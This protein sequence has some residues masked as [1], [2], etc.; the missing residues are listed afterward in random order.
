MEDQGIMALPMGG[1]QAPTTAPTAQAVPPELAAAIEASRSM[2]T[3]NEVSKNTLEALGE[4]DPELVTRFY[5][6]LAEMDL[7]PEVI[8][9]LGQMV[10][11]VLAEPQNY[12]QIRA[13]FIAE[14]V[15]ED[16]LPLEFDP[17]YFAA[18]N[19]ALDE[20][21][22]A[23]LPE[24]PVGFADGGVVMSPIA[25]QLASMGR[26]G[27]TMLAHI[28][29]SE[30]RMLRRRGGSGT[31]NPRTGLPEFF[32]KS[33]AKS[34]GNVFKGV[35]NAVKGVVKGLG[36]VIKDIAS[37]PLGRIAL[38]VAAVYFMG[39]AGLNFAGTAGSITG[40]TGATALG[41]NTAIASTVI[42]VASGQKFKDALKSGAIQ[43]LM[44]YG[45][46]T[47]MK[48]DPYAAAQAAEASKAS[49]TVAQAPTDA[50]PN[51]TETVS[52]GVRPEVL[53]PSDVSALPGPSIG[54]D[55]VI[56]YGPQN[57]NF[58]QPMQQFA[59]A[60]TGTATD[61]TTQATTQAAGQA[62]T[63]AAGQQSNL[64]DLVSEGGTKV[65]D[66]FFPKTDV[67]EVAKLFEQYKADL[68]LKFPGTD[69]KI[70]ATKAMEMAEKAA[71]PTFGTG[72]R[73]A[74]AGLTTLALTGGFTPKQPER[75]GIVPT[76]TGFDLLRRSPDIYGVRVGGGRTVYPSEGIMTLA[77]GGNVSTKIQKKATKTE[78]KAERL[79]AK[80]KTE[81]ANKL[82][83]KAD[84]LTAK[85][86]V[87]SGSF[88]SPEDLAVGA[89]AGQMVNPEYAQFYEMINTPSGLRL[90]GP[91]REEGIG[92]YIEDRR[93][94]ESGLAYRTRFFQEAA[95][96]L[97]TPDL[98]VQAQNQTGGTTG[99][100]GNEGTTAPTT[101]PPTIVP[102]TPIVST[103][104]ANVPS[105]QVGGGTSSAPLYGPS[106]IT[107]GE[108]PNPLLTA[109]N[110]QQLSSAPATSVSAPV[111]NTTGGM[112]S[113]P[114]AP[115]V[116]TSP[117]MYSWQNPA[118][119]TSYGLATQNNPFFPQ[120]QPMQMAKG[121]I[122]SLEEPRYFP[123]RNGHINGP[124]T[125]TSDDVPAMLS[126]GEFVFTAKAV[127]AAGN[128]SRRMGAKRMYAMMKALEKKQNG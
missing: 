104:G 5:R 94:G 117:N 52:Q 92:R 85:A 9:A 108:M 17:A 70:I 87:K 106:S 119:A 21:V 18:L 73:L 81:R 39:P 71:A 66:F 35:G 80:G 42:G 78:A 56:N 20:L 63:Q 86:A 1:M 8:D 33:L 24:T 34:V 77:Q 84:A 97:K 54:P 31:I 128:G 55:G 53:T 59:K 120:Q 113:V 41:V 58:A 122:A 112:E 79:E 37:S 88:M 64:F 62:T 48:A 68:N 89:P 4:E 91:T 57:P 65:K 95:D 61:A 109:P 38:T 125:G 46:A 23:E 107:V 44:A 43:G 7:P 32:L 25:A 123:R 76:E 72:A 126:D 40:L 102:T 121:G 69:P 50:I 114:Y 22:D 83:A 11:A 28:T 67:A 105:I 6:M 13:E 15:P 36:N 74:G 100:G 99:A 90:S 47:M 110:F 49:T 45:G 16:I 111:M 12:Q 27:D 115:S 98:Y 14:G 101:P 93:P 2:M 127:R 29:P 116:F 3:P 10:D 96:L 30:A 26:R 75:P 124:G 60:A 19:L 51:V 118:Y 103:G 82:Y